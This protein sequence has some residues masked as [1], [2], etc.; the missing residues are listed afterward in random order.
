MEIIKVR[1]FDETSGEFAY[2]ANDDNELYRWDFFEGK[3]F[4]TYERENPGDQDTPPYLEPIEVS[5]PYELWTGR[6]DKKDKEIYEGDVIPIEHDFGTEQYDNIR[7]I[8]EVVELQAGAFFPIYDMDD[9]E[10]E[11]IGTIHDPEFEGG[12]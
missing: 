1:A 10:I 4:C 2:S 8:N 3:P 9:S 5:G 6:K 7:V 12:L 11:I